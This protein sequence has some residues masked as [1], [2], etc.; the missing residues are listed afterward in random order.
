M[1]NP[2]EFER[3]RAYHRLI[4]LIFSAKLDPAKPL[5]ERKLAERLD[6][7]RMPVRE[8]LRQL[9]REGVVEV[10]PARGTFV[11]QLT[12]EDLVDTYRVRAAL[13]CLGSELA[14]KNGV[15]PALKAHGSTLRM[16]AQ[17]SSAFTTREIDDAGTV[18]HE[19]LMDASGSAA[20]CES[21]RLLRMRSRL[22]FHLPRY[23]DHDLARETLQEHIA[24]LEAVENRHSQ[25]AS[26]LMAAH[27]S[28]GLDLRIKLEAASGRD[29]RE[30]PEHMSPKETTQ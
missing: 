23:Y 25:H 15:T 3:D 22:V 30:R 28:R 27:L 5:S 13:E 8:A 11:R 10:K 12:S 29:R 24:I 9:E 6:M 17:D 21:V 18:F 26:E 1:D 7:G 20:L 19:R 14:A 16:M 4:D 2:F